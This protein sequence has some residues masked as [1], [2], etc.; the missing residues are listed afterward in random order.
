MFHFVCTQA[1]KAYENIR[2]G[3]P[4]AGQI[5][6]CRALVTTVESVLQCCTLETHQGNSTLL[7][8]RPQ[9]EGL[10][11][12][13]GNA[14]LRVMTKTRPAPGSTNFKRLAAFDRETS[15]LRIRI[16]SIGCASSSAEKIAKNFKKHLTGLR[17]DRDNLAACWPH[18]RF[19]SDT[20]HKRHPHQNSKN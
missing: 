14:C 13:E 20:V 8:D 6:S 15:E 16:R 3:P 19:P 1:Q 7:S 5:R 18:G 10:S 17:K 9:N 2:A 11:F 12:T 4:A